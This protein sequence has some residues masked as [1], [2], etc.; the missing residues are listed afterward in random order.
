M[1]YLLI[2][3]GLLSFN[4]LAAPV[5]VNK[6]DANAIAEALNGIGQKKAEAIVKF[7]QEHGQFKSLGDLQKVKGIGEKTAMQNKQDILFKDIKVS[8]K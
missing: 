8:Q 2:L 6:A 1:K 7:R 5:N 3:T 4:V